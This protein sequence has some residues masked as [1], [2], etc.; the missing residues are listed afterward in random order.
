MLLSAGFGVALEIKSRNLA[1]KQPVVAPLEIPAPAVVEAPVPAPTT[2]IAA[3]TKPVTK[4]PTPPCPNSMPGDRCYKGSG[5]R[6]FPAEG[7]LVLSP[8]VF[9]LEAGKTFRDIITI[10]SESGKPVRRPTSD[11][12]GSLDP[13]GLVLWE[14]HV[15]DYRDSWTMGIATSSI[16]GY[17]TFQIEVSAMGNSVNDFTKYKAIMTVTII[18]KPYFEIAATRLDDRTEPGYFAV[19]IKYSRIAGYSNTLPEPYITMQPYE[20]S[21]ELFEDGIDQYVFECDIEEP[22]P[23]YNITF[24]V[25]DSLGV[26]KSTSITISWP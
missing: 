22:D 24:S 6:I 15:T 20:E 25:T 3:A 13:A 11:L 5:E 9:T 17:G 4:T 12:P 2:Q 7:K 16:V 19:R 14:S 21:C 23:S 10:R 18:E 26:R 1:N 8:A